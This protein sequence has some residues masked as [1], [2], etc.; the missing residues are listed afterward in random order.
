[1]KIKDVSVSNTTRV[2]AKQKDVDSL[3]S[4]LWIQF[5]PGYRDYVTQLGE[6]ILGTLV[7]IYPPWR[8]DKELNEWRRRIDK[9][10][11]WDKGRK[12]LP[13]AR[14]LECVIVG[15]TS[16]GDELVFHPCRPG[17]M[18]VLPIDSEKIFDAGADLLEAVN[19]M[20][21]SGK[22]VSPCSERDFKPFDS[23]VETSNAAAGDEKV[24]DPPGESL[25]EIAT[26]A[27]RWGDRHN[28]LKIA[29]KDLKVG[30]K[31]GEQAELLGLAIAFQ[32]KY[33][34][35]RGCVGRFQVTDRSG[36]DLGMIFWNL[37]DGSHG[38]EYRWNEANLA[39]SRRQRRGS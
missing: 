6:G 4:E 18:F 12:L 21:S 7:R 33:H 16:N 2:L 3:E 19:W 15:D 31:P 24:V 23:R 38:C 1:M 27:K 13:K 34:Y 30:M 39:K 25:D 14:A 22:L 5:P 11:F 35:G 8:I 29:R 26:L 32:G 9:Y 17:H 28:V 20:C 37:D 10:W 36:L